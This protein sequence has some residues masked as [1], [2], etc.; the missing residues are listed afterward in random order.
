VLVWFHGGA[1]LAGAASAPVYD[2]AALAGTERVGVVAV[3]YRLGALGW[4][5]S[6]QLTDPETAH[7]SNLAS[8]TRWQRSGGF[9]KRG[10]D[11]GGSD[12]CHRSGGVGRCGQRSLP[13]PV[14]S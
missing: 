12:A 2:G 5:A 8:R 1:Y 7:W 13:C 6:P 11:R 10:R 14:R 4:A 3:G 9:R